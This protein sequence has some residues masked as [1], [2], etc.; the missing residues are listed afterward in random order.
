MTETLKQPS[1]VNS[2][3]FP[4]AATPSPRAW[5]ERRP[6]RTHHCHGNLEDLLQGPSALPQL[7]PHEGNGVDGIKWFT[8]SKSEAKGSEESL[9]PHTQFFSKREKSLQIGSAKTVTHDVCESV[10]QYHVGT[11]THDPLSPLKTLWYSY[12]PIQ[13]LVWLAQCWLGSSHPPDWQRV[14]YIP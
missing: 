1:S 4:D 11:G 13:N 3:A 8:W 12:N 6:L 9:S 5:V 10:A 2:A 7:C 14:L